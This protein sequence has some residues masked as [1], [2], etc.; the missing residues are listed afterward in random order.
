MSTPIPSKELMQAAATACAGLQITAGRYLTELSPDD[1]GEV[2]NR[3]EIARA[4]AES[5]DQQGIR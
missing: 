4:M 5:L 2:L 3:P 1:Y